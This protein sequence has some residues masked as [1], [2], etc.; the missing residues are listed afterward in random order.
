MQK[1]YED[2]QL[3]KSKFARSQSMN[4]QTS[5][6]VSEVKANVDV[7]LGKSEGTGNF[8]T[9]AQNKIDNLRNQMPNNDLAKRGNMAI[10]D[11]KIE[12]IKSEFSAHS[13]I[14]SMSDR[15]ADIANFSL[16]KL[17]SE[18]IFETYEPAASKIGGMP[19]D[20]FHDTEAK[21]L[22]DIASQ[23]KDPKVFGIIDLYT[24]LPVCQSCT[25]IIFEF[26][27]NFTNIKL[28]VYTK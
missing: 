6:R 26:R 4:A 22:E 14:D 17:E 19:F 12:G 13:K 25:N 24:E 23:V 21:I 9:N 10:A 11:V 18:R 1:R 5:E 20:R 27:R 16:K 28:N 2:L 3:Q 7:S 8:K 15:G